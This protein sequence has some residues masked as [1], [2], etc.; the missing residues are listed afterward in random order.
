[1]IEALAIIFLVLGFACQ[2]MLT[3]A[4]FTAGMVGVVFL[5]LAIVPASTKSDSPAIWR[6]RALNIA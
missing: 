3:L 1:M 4:K 5:T 2:F 6:L